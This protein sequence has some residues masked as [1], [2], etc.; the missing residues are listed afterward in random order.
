MVSISKR[1]KDCIFPLTICSFSFLVRVLFVFVHFFAS[2]IFFSFPHFFLLTPQA[3]AQAKIERENKDIRNEQLLL[4]AKE[5]RTTGTRESGQITT[6]NKDRKSQR[7]YRGY[8]HYS[9]CSHPLT[10]L[11]RPIPW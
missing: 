3:E 10:S 6:D 1:S 11:I 5:Y 2:I 4:Q 9:I 8:E 7:K